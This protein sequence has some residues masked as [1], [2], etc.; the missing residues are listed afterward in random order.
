MMPSA[1]R[2]AGS[3]S[4]AARSGA[5]SGMVRTASARGLTGGRSSFT[6]GRPATAHG[7]TTPDFFSRR[8]RSIAAATSPA[9]AAGARPRGLMLEMH[10]AVGVGGAGRRLVDVV[11][12]ERV[13]EA[14]AGPLAAGEQ[15]R[16]RA[17]EARD[18]VHDLH[19]RVAHEE[20]RRV[21][22]A[23][24]G[25]RRQQRAVELGQVLVDRRR[26]QAVAVDHHQRRRAADP[27]RQL[28]ARGVGQ[29]AAEIGALQ[30]RRLVGRARRELEHPQA[31]A[32][33]PGRPRTARRPWRRRGR[34]GSAAWCWCDSAGRCARRR[35]APASTPGCPA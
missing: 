14:E 35:C 7:K 1:R 27:A 19:A 30:E 13:G 16:L 5:A 4:D 18:L 28:F 3:P 26:R 32:A 23:A 6:N 10:L 22:D 15:R 31:F 25:E 34:R 20:G 8:M 21:A 12:G 9:A 11:G 33:A 29:R 24:R 2:S 17:G